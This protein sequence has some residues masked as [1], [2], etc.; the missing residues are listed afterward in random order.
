MKTF[1]FK[2]SIIFSVTLF[3]SCSSDD[4]GGTLLL[5]D[6]ILMV[7]DLIEII[8]E[9]QEVAMVVAQFAVTQ[10]NLTTPL[11]FEI[12]KVSRAGAVTVN[13]QGQLLVGDAT[14]FDFERRE[15]I[16]GEIQVSSGDLVQT[17]SFTL[18]LT[19]EV[20]DAVPF[21]TRWNLVAGDL[22]VQ[23]P[24]YEGLANDP[25]EY[26]F[27]VDWGDG[28]P[29]GLVTS[30]DDPDAQHTYFFEGVQTVT[31]TGILKG[32]NFGEN[33]T[34]RNLI[35]D[36]AQWGDVQ[37]GNGGGYFA[38]CENLVGFS[39]T[40]TPILKEVTNMDEM[41]RLAVSFTGDLSNWDVSNVTSMSSMFLDAF[42]F[43]SDI[44]DWDVSN[45]TTM[46]GMFL[47]A[48][49]FNSDISNWDVSNVTNM[50]SMFSG[51]LAPTR[52]MK[53]NQDISKWDV[54]NVTSMSGM[55]AAAVNFNQDLSNWDVSSVTTMRSMFFRARDFNQDLSNWDVS[56]VTD[57]TLMFAGSTNISFV[58]T[59]FNQDISNWDVSSVMTM[60]GMFAENRAFNSDI[61]GWDVSN[62]T[63]MRIMFENATNF[64]QNLSNWN[65]DNVTDC[66]NFANGSGLSAEQIP[67][68]GICF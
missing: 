19:D 32:F 9:N 1:F 14:A 27:L 8:P 64:S 31:I 66:E 65:T 37:I 7:S 54:S 2:F 13:N 30:F 23:L 53:F 24:L 60:E 50:A 18:N 61:S 48:F 29:E 59:M 4:D 22:T 21:I 35:V 11:I 33:L 40:D 12:L 47:G 67:I 25:T 36:V 16:S 17:A 26:N 55:F 20:E 57:M 3:F 6:P 49:N 34:S 15:T 62:V 44:S 63:N 52:S 51:F 58:P 5:D 28:S 39:A 38:F 46:G 56:N 41:F 43:D 68:N 45:V 10:E 42:S